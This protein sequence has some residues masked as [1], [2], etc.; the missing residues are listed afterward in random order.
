MISKKGQIYA[1]K[2]NNYNRISFP[3]KEENKYKDCAGIHAEAA[4]INSCTKKQL[5]NSEIVIFGMTI[6]GNILRCTFP[7][8]SCLNAIKSVGIRK[9]TY[10]DDYVFKS[11]KTN[12]L[13]MNI[14]TPEAEG[15]SGS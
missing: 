8:E 11:V 9:I 7:C 14:K 4:V 6:A 13:D 2:T 10:L 15:T 3:H 5:K 12:V 1:I